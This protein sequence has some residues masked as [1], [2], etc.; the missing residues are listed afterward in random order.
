VTEGAESLS[1]HFDDIRSLALI[2]AA[3]NRQADGGYRPE[4][5]RLLL[6]SA[7]RLARYRSAAQA[8]IAPVPRRRD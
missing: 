3:D 4:T 8:E 2:H 5:V 6:A 1:G 7:R